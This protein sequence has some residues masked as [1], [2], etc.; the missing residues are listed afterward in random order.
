MSM[1]PCIVGDNYQSWRSR[2]GQY[3][4]HELSGTNIYPYIH[5]A[6]TVNGCQTPD[7]HGVAGVGAALDDVEAGDNGERTT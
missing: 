5:P 3:I 4:T 6:T 7:E 2:D 1:T